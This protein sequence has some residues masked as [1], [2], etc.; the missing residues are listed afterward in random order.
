[1]RG[2]VGRIVRSGD[3]GDIRAECIGEWRRR[4]GLHVCACFQSL[5]LFSRVFE[6][7]PLQLG[8]QGPVL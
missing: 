8:R 7:G 6:G 2:D 5:W 3:V 4:G 1:M